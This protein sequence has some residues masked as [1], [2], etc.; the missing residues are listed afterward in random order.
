[1][2][3]LCGSKL[4][5]NSVLPL[6]NSVTKKRPLA[7]PELLP[8]VGIFSRGEGELREKEGDDFSILPLTPAI[9]ATT[10]HHL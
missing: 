8:Y 2:P 9:P 10:L 7:A 6:L 4:I 1:M 3:A 5:L